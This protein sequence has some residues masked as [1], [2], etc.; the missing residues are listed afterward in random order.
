MYVTGDRK[1]HNE[2]FLSTLFTK[3]YRENSVCQRQEAQNF[4]QKTRKARSTNFLSENQKGR[5]AFF[6]ETP[7]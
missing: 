3:H 7:A 5:D 4:V 6:F 2:N 1:Q